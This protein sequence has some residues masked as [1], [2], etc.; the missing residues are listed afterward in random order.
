MTPRSDLSF[1]WHCTSPGIYE[2]RLY[3]GEIPL[4]LFAY[5]HEGLTAALKLPSL[6]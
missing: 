3:A 5:K 6:V 1:L 2:R 4:A